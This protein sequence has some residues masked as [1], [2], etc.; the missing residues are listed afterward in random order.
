MGTYITAGPD[1]GLL[2]TSIF[3]IFANLPCQNLASTRTWQTIF[4]QSMRT[5]DGQAQAKRPGNV[6]LMLP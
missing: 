6:A 2:K 1:L 5:K 4:P 3:R